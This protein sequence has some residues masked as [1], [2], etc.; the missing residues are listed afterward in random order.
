M[1]DYSSDTPYS[2]DEVRTATQLVEENYDLLARMARA[3]RRRA[4]MSDTMSTIDILHESFLKLNGQVLWHSSEHFVRSAALAMR[5][6]I[7]DHAR[8]RMAQKRGSGAVRLN[9][10]DMENLMPEYS[11]S[12]EDIVAIARL[13]EKLETLNPRWMRIVD[14]RYFAGMTETETAQ[15]LALSERTVRR[16]WKEA[17]EWIAQQLG[18]TE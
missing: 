13:L 12:P 14:A 5:H 17:R 8:R 18:V 2:E 16:D 7:I 10:E 4:N 11:E 1:G 15:M 3:K 9:Y 6:V